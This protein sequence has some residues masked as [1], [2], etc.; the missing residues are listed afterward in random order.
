M[1]RRYASPLLKKENGELSVRQIIELHDGQFVRYYPFE[2]ELP[3]TIW[4]DGLIEI[5]E[6]KGVNVAY[7]LTPY[8]CINKKPVDETQRIRL[9]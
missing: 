8:D 2:Q 7:H 5:V 3:A 9:T 4:L 1:I 6:E